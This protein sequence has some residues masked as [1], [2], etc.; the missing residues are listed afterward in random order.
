[1]TNPSCEFIFLLLYC[2]VYMCLSTPSSSA[3]LHQTPPQPCL[4][5]PLPPCI[6]SLQIPPAPQTAQSLTAEVQYR[7]ASLR[8][9]LGM[10]LY[11]PSSFYVSSIPP[12]LPQLLLRLKRRCSCLMLTG[13]DAETLTY[14]KYLMLNILPGKDLFSNLAFFVSSPSGVINVTGASF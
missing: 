10:P 1:M 2:F 3:S 11:I 7:P 5:P 13:Q 6:P 14:G 12:P 4:H 8:G 9:H